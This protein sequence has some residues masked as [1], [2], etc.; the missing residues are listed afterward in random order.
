M[1]SPRLLS[2]A[3]VLP[4]GR[5]NA[6]PEFGARNALAAE[7]VRQSYCRASVAGFFR[8]RYRA[9]LVEPGIPL[10]EIV[11]FIHLSPVLEKLVSI[12]NLL[13]FRWSSFRW[14]VRGTNGRP[15][16][17]SADWLPVR[18]GGATPMRAGRTMASTSP[19]SWPTRN[20]GAEEAFDRMERDW[21]HGSAAYRRE[22]L[23]RLSDRTADP[24]A[25]AEK[26]A[27]ERQHWQAC[28]EAGAKVLD[29]T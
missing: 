10:A 18:C 9:V 4:F 27:A 25:G 8:G 6:G 29:Q 11:D 21:M 1:A 3:A 2:A 14:F 15:T 12:E 26:A 22:S 13:Q 5:G 20:G 24:A 16:L 23:A 19:G 17:R 28:I 7:R